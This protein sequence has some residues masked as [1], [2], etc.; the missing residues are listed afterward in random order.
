[1]D[2][3]INENC[4]FNDMVYET[5]SFKD[6]I[7]QLND[8][9]DYVLEQSLQYD[10]LNIFYPDGRMPIWY[11]NYKEEIEEAEAMSSVTLFNKKIADSDIILFKRPNYLPH[12]YLLLTDANAVSPFSTSLINDKKDTVFADAVENYKLGSQVIVI[13]MPNS[14]YSNRH[15]IPII[16]TVNNKEEPYLVNLPCFQDIQAINKY[17]IIH[18]LLSNIIRD[19][20]KLTEIISDYQKFTFDWKSWKPKENK[21]PASVIT[22]KIDKISTYK[23]DAKNPSRKIAVFKEIGELMA[24]INGY[25]FNQELTSYN[26]KIKGMRAIYEAGEDNNKI[27]LSIDFENGP[28][29]V[30][31]YQG[32][33]LGEY[34]YKGEK[35]HG[36]KAGHDILIP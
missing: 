14:D 15:F 30:C 26:Q 34:N 8:I 35:N 1:M 5:S 10:N 9:I 12:Y 31:D 16:K 7:M 24:R 33:H 29:E 18:L 21:F 4:S 22:S 19:K 17:L 25:K 6:T 32:C 36:Y 23:N 2:I 11:K 3:F 20:E 27:Y 13:N 28:F